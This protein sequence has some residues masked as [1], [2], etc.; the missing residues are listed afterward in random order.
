MESVRLSGICKTDLIRTLLDTV[1]KLSEDAAVPKSDNA[2]LKFQISELHEKL[3]KLRDHCPPESVYKQTRKPLTYLKWPHV[4]IQ[5]GA[6]PQLQFL[7]LRIL[8]HLR[9][10]LVIE[11]LP[12]TLHQLI[13]HLR[14]LLLKKLSP[15]V[16]T[17]K[18]CRQCGTLLIYQLLLRSKGS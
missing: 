1:H 17:V 15:T 9:K 8:L 11:E 16:I 10:Y 7:E 5:P 14:F 3:A 6:M 2:S 18:H 4:G 13:L 12:R